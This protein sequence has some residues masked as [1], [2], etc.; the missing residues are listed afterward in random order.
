MCFAAWIERAS[1]T[2]DEVITKAVRSD[3]TSVMNWHV[4][5]LANSGTL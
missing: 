5:P 2:A 4:L 1:T 3:A